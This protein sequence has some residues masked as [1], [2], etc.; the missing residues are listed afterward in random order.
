MKPMLLYRCN[1]FCIKM[2]Q[3]SMCRGIPNG[4]MGKDTVLDGYE[5]R[6]EITSKE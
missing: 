3:R 4:S 6:I 5:N 1:K 2:R